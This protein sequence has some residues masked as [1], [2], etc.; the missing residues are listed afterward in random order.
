MVTQDPYLVR[1]VEAF[2]AAQQG[3]AYLGSRDLGSYLFVDF[4]QNRK[5]RVQ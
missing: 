4:A 3:R 1:F 5:R 2:H